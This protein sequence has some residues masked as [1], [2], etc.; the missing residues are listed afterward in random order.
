MA[1]PR[2]C[3]TYVPFNKLY[4]SPILQLT[5]KRELLL[6]RQSKTQLHPSVPTNRI[7][8]GIKYKCSNLVHDEI[9]LY[10]T[11]LRHAGKAHEAVRNNGRYERQQQGSGEYDSLGQ[12]RV[13]G[14]FWGRDS[15]DVGFVGGQN[16]M[17][18]KLHFGLLAH[19]YADVIQRIEALLP[20][21]DGVLTLGIEHQE[22]QGAHDP[23][24]VSYES[25]LKDSPAGN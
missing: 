10:E 23:Y 9:Q 16:C 5:Q 15:V 22:Q 12:E 7:L 4:S 2:L 24:V 3:L 20:L 6:A 19:I 8:N 14:R 18:K 25:P 11:V 17:K 13:D 1:P 21:R